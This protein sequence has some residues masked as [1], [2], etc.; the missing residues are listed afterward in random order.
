[1]KM[2]KIKK[3][4]IQSLLEENFSNHPSTLKTNFC[5]FIFAD[6][7]GLHDVLEETCAES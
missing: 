6:V 1:M 2:K 5:E 7:P 4:N 3:Q